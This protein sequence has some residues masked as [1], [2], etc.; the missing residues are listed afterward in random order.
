MLQMKNVKIIGS[1]RHHRLVL[2]FN[3]S[4]RRE[5]FPH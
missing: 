3:L 1:Y 5:K 2:Y 4:T